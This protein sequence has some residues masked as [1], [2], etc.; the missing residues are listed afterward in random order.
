[1]TTEELPIQTEFGPASETLEAISRGLDEYNRQHIGDYSYER[2]AAVV[3]GPDGSVVGG[4][5]GDLLWDWL[6]VQSLWVHPDYRGQALGSRLL[7]AIEAAALSHGITKAH[8]ETTSFQARGYY[9]RHGYVVFGT[10]EGKPAGVTWYYLKHTNLQD[11]GARED[12]PSSPP[13][14]A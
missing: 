11:A 9:E 6:Y 5:F 8:L 10:L 4:A 7:R 13:A 2:A 14:P 1:M 3:R 12:P